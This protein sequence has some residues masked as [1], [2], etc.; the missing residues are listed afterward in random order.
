M[1]KKI[2]NIIFLIVVVFAGYFYRDSIKE[3]YIR[4]YNNYFPCKQAIEYD[5]GS[6]DP[7]FGIS[8]EEFLK[9]LTSAEAIWEK[10]IDRNLFVYKP[11]GDLKI[12][13]I[14][15]V[16]QKAT[17]EL[18][19][20][21]L[22]VDNNK[23]SYDELKSKY[24]SLITLHE[25]DATNYT[26]NVKEFEIRKSVYEA[27]VTE[28]KNSKR[29]SQEMADK[30][31]AEREYLNSRIPVLNQM[32]DSLNKQVDNINALVL[33][34]NQLAKFLNLDVEKY[35]SIGDSLPG[36]FDEG[37]YKS[38]PQGRE[39][40]VYQFDNQTKLI[41]VLAHEFG[42]ALGLDHVEDPKAIMFRLN[43]GI[44]EKITNI[45]L[46]ELKAKCGIK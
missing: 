9:A 17:V 23:A 4:S 29:V 44:N 41:R 11:G 28:I 7:R 40:D 3:I 36:E 31:N 18:K 25:R 6:F 43:N 10:S 16:R 32:Q 42:H 34:I 12:N 21:G 27:N 26:S 15:D 19:K 35:N 8:K 38:G 46:V 24:N 20:M 33:A 5:I 45:D 1:T 22:V 39:I 14:Y 37:M 13:L 30:L 2:L